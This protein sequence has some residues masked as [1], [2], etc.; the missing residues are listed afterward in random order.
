MGLLLRLL[1]LPLLASCSHQG[2]EHERGASV[3]W[4]LGFC[5]KASGEMRHYEQARTVVIPPIGGGGDAD[6]DYVDCDAVC[7]TGGQE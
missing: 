5:G 4:C 6:T 1:V 3:E 2:I 7:S